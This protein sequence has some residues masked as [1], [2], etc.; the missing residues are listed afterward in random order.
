MECSFLTLFHIECRLEV[1]L[2]EKKGNCDYG[3]C[4]RFCCFICNNRVL[5]SYQYRHDGPYVCNQSKQ[6]VIGKDENLSP[7]TLWEGIG[8]YP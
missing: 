8:T 5:W 4:N 6:P 1:T 7:T 3:V 2:D